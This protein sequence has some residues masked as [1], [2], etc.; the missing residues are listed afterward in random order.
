MFWATVW[1]S[2]VVRRHGHRGWPNGRGRRDPVAAASGMDD[3]R[4]RD[5]P[6]SEVRDKGLA[7]LPPVKT[8]P[9]KVRT[10]WE[11]FVFMLCRLYLSEQPT[12]LDA[13]T[14]TISVGK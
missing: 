4:H 11:Y 12:M 6:W 10:I 13:R 9:F 2:P 7:V 8:L 1:R 3:A 5:H 14:D